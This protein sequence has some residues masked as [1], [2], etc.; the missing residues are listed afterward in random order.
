MKGNIR[1]LIFVF[2]LMVTEVYC[3]AEDFAPGIDLFNN[4]NYTDART[5]FMSR[6]NSGSAS[7][8][9]Y[10]Y[11]GRIA[12]L[13]NELDNSIEQF[14]KAIALSKTSDYY[15]WL[16]C[17][18]GLKAQRSPKLKQALLVRK[19]KNA[20]ETAVQMDSLNIPA[21]DALIQ[22][23]TMAPSIMG[24][25][26]NTAMSLAQQMK[27]IDPVR[28]HQAL[29]MVYERENK[30]DLAETEY[31]TA[32]QLA[33]DEPVRYIQLSNWYRNQKKY[34]KA[35]SSIQELLIKEPANP[36]ALCHL[37]Y[38]Y[39]DLRQFDNAFSAFDRAL[40]IDSTNATACYQIGRTAIFSGQQLDRAEMCFKKYIASGNFENNPSEAYAHYRL[41][42]VYE[43][44]KKNDQA[45]AEYLRA[46][47][48]DGNFKEAKEA[49]KKLK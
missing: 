6:V 37:G 10:Y 21:M 42:M 4:K 30:I 46:I 39:Q 36:E 43:V 8:I 26:K 18:Y 34:D 40:A 33:P 12:Y 11:L 7:A 2:I 22:Y 17:A 5:Y 9:P 14:E 31:V 3:F 47:D 27:R 16:G 20:F 35:Q 15:Y 29:G 41:G 28:G 24:G 48:L 25:D 38:I 19:I 1:L 13:E 45:K 23:H 44:Q 32:F 49:L